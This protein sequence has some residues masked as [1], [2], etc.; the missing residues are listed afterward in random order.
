[1]AVSQ[2]SYIGIGVSDTA[3]WKQ[4]ATDVLGMQVGE[5]PDAGIVYLRMDEYHHR[6]IVHPTG[7]DDV[8]YAGFQAPTR[9]EYE[10]TKQSLS[11]L[12][13]IYSQGTTEDLDVRKVVD[14]VKFESGGLNFELSFGPAVTYA[15]PFRPG[16][17]ISGFKTGELGLGHI[18]LRSRDQADTVRV[19]TEGLG[20]RLSDYVGNMVFMHCNPRHHTIA[21]QPAPVVPEGVPTKKM[22][23]FMTELNSLDD[24]GLGFDAATNSETAPVT[25]IGKHMNDHMISFYVLTPSGFEIEYGWGGRLIDD[26]NWQVVKHLYG[27]IWGHKSMRQG[28]PAMTQPVAA[29]VAGG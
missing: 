8:L 12:G 28:P 10:A 3:A 5:E 16:R 14:L 9:A 1:M 22:W 6:V 4:F 7:E 2:L 29:A 11:S 26:D 17:A 18:V 25:T 13:V 15:R 20:F 19:L 21:I 23:H 27:D 24:V